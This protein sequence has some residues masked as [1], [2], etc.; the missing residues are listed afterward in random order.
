[1]PLA[2]QSL[3]AEK[4]K[5]TLALYKQ[6]TWHKEET[7]LLSSGNTVKNLTYLVSSWL[8]LLAEEEIMDKKVTLQAV[9]IDAPHKEIFLSFDRTPFANKGSTFQKLM[10]V[11]ALLKTLASSGVQAQSVRFLVN[12]KPLVDPHLDFSCPWPLSGYLPT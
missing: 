1:M 12:H 2:L 7:E 4:K 11:E 9:L 10:W 3:G 6:G 8:T 5:F